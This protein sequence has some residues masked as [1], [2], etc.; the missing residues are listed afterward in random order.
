MGIAQY[1]IASAA[2]S[3][4]SSNHHFFFWRTEW[5][6]QW[7]ID[8]FESFTMV[9]TWRFTRGSQRDVHYCISAATRV[10]TSFTFQLHVPSMIKINFLLYAYLLK[11]FI[12]AWLNTW[13]NRHHC[14]SLIT[15]PS[16]MSQ[17]QKAAS[18]SSIM[19]VYEWFCWIACISWNVRIIVIFSLFHF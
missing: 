16:S 3:I 8:Q 5:S 10:P 1:Y 12:F 15:I 14:L 11:V 18:D 6:L 9:A 17:I 2:H 7:S 13:L 4:A 19:D